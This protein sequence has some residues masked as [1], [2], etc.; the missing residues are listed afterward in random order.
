MLPIAPQ[1]PWEYTGMDFE[2]PLPHTPSGH[3]YLLVFEDYFYKCIEVCAVKEAMAQVAASKFIPSA[4]STDNHTH[5]T[6]IQAYVGDKHMSW[7]KYL[8]QICF[9]MRTAVHESMGFSLSMM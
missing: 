4:L 2:G 1:K 3:A 9:A 8:S 7:D 6:A 5:K